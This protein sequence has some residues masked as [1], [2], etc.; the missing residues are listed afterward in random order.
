MCRS[1]FLISYSGKFSI[2]QTLNEK[3]KPKKAVLSKGAQKTQMIFF[4]D[5]FV[6]QK[7]SNSIRLIIS[8]QRCE[9]SFQH[10]LASCYQRSIFKKMYPGQG[11]SKERHVSGANNIFSHYFQL[12]LL[13]SLIFYQVSLC[14]IFTLS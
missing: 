6:H 7:A 11:R 8:Q 2:P 3:P 14:E 1:S 10:L 13:K 12:N 5:S 9:V 4:K